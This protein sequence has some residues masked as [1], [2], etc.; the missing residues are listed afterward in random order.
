MAFF[1]D[2]NIVTISFKVDKKR[3]D[4]YELARSILNKSDNELFEDFLSMVITKALRQNRVNDEEEKKE[5]DKKV[6]AEEVIRSRII[7]W[8]DAINS[9]PHIMIKSYLESASIQG[10]LKAYR[11]KVQGRFCDLT[12]SDPDKFYSI[13][14][15]MCSDSSRA[16]GDIFIN[17]RVRQ[18]IY[19]NEKYEC[20]ILNL[21]ETFLK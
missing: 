1:D 11:S 20:Y 8:A 4:Y 10:S 7:K 17:D 2:E 6:L 18:E 5:V 21:K 14:R 19:L 13:F 16:Y 15:Q 12:N 9:Y 3:A